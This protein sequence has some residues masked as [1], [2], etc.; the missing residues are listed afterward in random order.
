ME[1]KTI[2][3]LQHR[4]MF[5][6]FIDKGLFVFPER[7]YR[8][9]QQ[10]ERDFVFVKRKYLAKG[11]DSDGERVVCTACN[12]EA[13]P[14]DMVFPLC[15]KLHFVV[16]ERCAQEL[17]FDRGLFKKGKDKTTMACPHC[18]DV[19]SY[20]QRKGET[21]RVLF[22]SMSQKTCL[23]FEISLETN[24]ETVVR[25]VLETEVF[26]DNICVSDTL[27]FGLMAR[28]DVK[29]RNKV[30]LFHHSN[31]LDCCFE[32]PG[33][34]TDEQI[35]IRAS[36]G[37]G[38]E[39]AEQIHA[40][41]KK[42]PSNSIAINTQK[43]YAAEKDVC[44]LLKLCAGAEYNL[45]VFL[46]SSRKEY[47]EEILNTENS[48]VWIGK[49]KNLRLGR[50]AVSIL[51]RLG[52]HDENVMDELRLDISN[53]EQMAEITKTENKSIWVGKVKTLRLEGYAAGILPRLRFHE[54]NEMEVLGLRVCVSGNITEILSTESKSIWIGKVKNL[55]LERYAV[56]ILPKL[57]IHRENEMEELRLTAYDFGHISEILKTDNK[58]IWI[59]KVK[60]LRL[61]R[62]AVEILPKLVFH[63]ENEMEV[64]G[65]IAGNPENIVEAIKTESKSIWIGKVK[66]LSLERYAV[67]ILS[68]FKFHKEN[69]TE[70][71]RLTAYD[72][73][74]IS[75][76]LKTDNKSVWIGKVKILRLERYAVEI[77]PKLGFHEEN[78]IKVLGLGIYNP[79]NITEILKAENKSIWIGKVGVLK[80]ERYAVEILPKLG[81]HEENEINLFSLGIY[82]SEDIAEILKTENNSIW[83]G[84]MKKLNL[85]GYATDILPKLCFHKE[86]EMEV[87]NLRADHPGHITGILDTENSSIWIGKVKTLRLER[88]AVK[89][90]AKLRTS[91]ENEMEELTLIANDLEH[92]SEIEKTENNSIWIGKVRTLRLEGYAVEILPKLR[93]HEENEMEVLDLCADHPENIAEVEKIENSSIWVGKV[94]TLR[95]EGYAVKTIEKLGFHKENEMEE[96]GLTAT[97]S[98][99]VA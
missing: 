55:S 61:E 27:F 51:P 97:H 2:T 62:Y 84:K 49:I 52:I 47:V 87:L 82:N 25:L 73:G 70:E 48:S 85:V 86:N 10:N 74:H 59:G 40:N 33:P 19:L 78:E 6:V 92:I 66:N 31:S 89:A 91:E 43:I 88:Y 5:F 18:K 98:E 65:L 29:I 95:L 32:Q 38:E 12:E 36:T 90:L 14:E 80:L 8:L 28:T 96:V 37:Y 3:A 99:N 39:E 83:M 26:L 9:F 69:E 34:R 24:I 13:A 11:E 21:L 15:R 30:S 16:C 67:G 53:S 23:R 42:M 58:S 77:L 76:I 7:E 41:L 93:F 75:E 64:L 1:K 35:D 22:S 63:E 72:F 71:L 46:E 54:E 60:I 68:K 17:L 44:I 4:N 94:K 56:G 45:D 50:Y 57:G 20:E 79:E 81:F